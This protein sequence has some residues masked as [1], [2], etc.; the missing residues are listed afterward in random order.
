MEKEYYIGK[1]IKREGNNNTYMIIR[2]SR[3]SALFLVNLTLGYF[4][5]NSVSHYTK[6]ISIPIDET[7]FGNLLKGQAAKEFYMEEDKFVLPKKWYIKP[8]TTE[9][10]EILKPFLIKFS[11]FYEK[12]IVSYSENTY[13]FDGSRIEYQSKGEEIEPEFKEITIEQF[14]K[15][16]LKEN[17]MQEIKK[18]EKLTISR[19]NLELLYKSVENCSEWKNTIK[20]IIDVNPIFASE[21]QF[22]ANLLSQAR[23]EANA[24]QKV[25]LDKIFPNEGITKR[26]FN[27]DNI[28]VLNEDLEHYTNSLIC[29]RNNGENEDKALVLDGKYTYELTKDKDGHDILFIK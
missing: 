17:S 1:P 16:V 23:K 12:F 21:F 20:T 6:D 25:L 9:N 11:H 8:R 24:T 19:E 15:Y 3:K 28:D 27:Y 22:N 29:V 10:L 4:F 26:V 5:A 7:I 2:N 14:Q 13:L 18:V